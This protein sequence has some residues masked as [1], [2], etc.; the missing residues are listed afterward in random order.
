MERI[1]DTELQNHK[2]EQIN[3]GMQKSWDAKKESNYVRHCTHQSRSGAFPPIPLLL[4][5]AK[6]LTDEPRPG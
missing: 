2:I 3:R 4:V 6:H 5:A 1:N